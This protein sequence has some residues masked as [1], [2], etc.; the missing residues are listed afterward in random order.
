MVFNTLYHASNIG[1]I[2]NCSC[3]FQFFAGSC[4]IYLSDDR[5]I[6]LSPEYSVTRVLLCTKTMEL[7][8]LLYLPPI[9]QWIFYM[10]AENALLLSI[11]PDSP[12]NTT[13][14]SPPPIFPFIDIS[15][16]FLCW[17]TTLSFCYL[18]PPSFL[19]L[20]LVISSVV[21]PSITSHFPWLVPVSSAMNMPLA[22]MSVLYTDH[23]F[24]IINTIKSKKNIQ[25]NV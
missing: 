11:I 16:I 15:L 13:L 20:L 17:I 10:C 2:T 24:I 23:A 18:I 9:H 8:P 5:I 25:Q 14:F 12:Q 3:C 19:Y 4:P 6:F 1:Y 21:H 22:S 7:S